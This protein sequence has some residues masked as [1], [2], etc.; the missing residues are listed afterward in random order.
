MEIVTQIVDLLP[1]HWEEAEFEIKTEPRPDDEV[2]L[3]LSIASPEGYSDYVEPTDGLFNLAGRLIHLMQQYGH[4]LA[5]AMY[6]IEMTPEGDWDFKA[7][8]QYYD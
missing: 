3:Q 8:Y 1:E 2:S 7:K 4:R 5:K 6:E